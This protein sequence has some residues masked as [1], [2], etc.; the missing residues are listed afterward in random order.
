[1]RHHIRIVR[2]AI[3]VVGNAV[4]FIRRMVK[5]VCRLVRVVGNAVGIVRIIVWVV[6][7]FVR[8]VKDG[9]GSGGEVVVGVSGNPSGVTGLL[10]I[11]GGVGGWRL[12]GVRVIQD[13]VTVTELL[14]IGCYCGIC[15]LVC[16]GGFQARFLKTSFRAVIRWPVAF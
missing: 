15:A 7:N 13:T 12:A 3:R 5:T 10:I 6:R 11:G 1:M 8:V 16:F 14:L 9:W 2:G 4:W